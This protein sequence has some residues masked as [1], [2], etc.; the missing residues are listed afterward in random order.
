MGHFF[1]LPLRA[2]IFILA[3]GVGHVVKAAVIGSA[4]PVFCS[5]SVCHAASAA[6]ETAT[7]DT[8]ICF[9]FYPTLVS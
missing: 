2:G 6:N 5:R 1:F 3:V 8:N 7:A 9:F 4:C